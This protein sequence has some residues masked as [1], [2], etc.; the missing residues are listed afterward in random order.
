MF[1]CVHLCQICGLVRLIKYRCLK[2]RIVCN[3]S[4]N[5][6]GK[7]WHELEYK[8]PKYEYMMHEFTKCPEFEYKTKESEYKYRQHRLELLSTSRVSLQ[9]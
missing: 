9:D 1:V 6:P 7:C 4:K 5:L 8:A 2:H 3:H